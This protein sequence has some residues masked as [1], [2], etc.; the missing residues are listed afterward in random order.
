MCIISE[1]D[2]TVR[3]IPPSQAP[4]CALHRGVKCSKFLKKLRDANHPA[5]L[6]ARGSWACISRPIWLAAFLKTWS[7][8]VIHGLIGKCPL[9]NWFYKLPPDQASRPEETKIVKHLN[10]LW[11]VL[12]L[13]RL[14]NK[15]AP[16]LAKFFLLNN[17]FWWVSKALKF[18]QYLFSFSSYGEKIGLHIFVN[19]SH[20]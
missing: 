18:L 1:S 15:L 12:P 19:C 16:S 10:I 17:R 9:Q 20:F 14:E 13:S 5:D 8:C 11:R 6:Q 2:S 3:V 4:L 7:F